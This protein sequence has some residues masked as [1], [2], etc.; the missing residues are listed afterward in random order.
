MIDSL[1]AVSGTVLAW[2]VLLGTC[3][4]VIYIPILVLKLKR[5]VIVDW[6]VDAAGIVEMVKATLVPSRLARK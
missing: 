1:I 6:K 2:A 5:R 3:S 4:I